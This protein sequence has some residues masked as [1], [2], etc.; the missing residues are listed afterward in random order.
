MKTEELTAL[1][2]GCRTY[3]RFKQDPVPLEV[4]EAAVDN[5]RCANCSMNKQPLRYAIATSSDL[6]KAIT[7][8]VAFAGR[9]PKEIGTP[10]SNEIPTAFVGISVMQGA[11]PFAAVDL[12]IAAYALTTTAWSAGVGSCMMGAF[13]KKAVGDLLQIPED[14]EL[15]LLIALGYPDHAS[16]VVD[17]S[18]DGDIG[19]Y[20]DEARDYYVPKLP[21][22]TVARFL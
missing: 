15:Q 22:E 5:A 6:V 3:R 7:E 1:F 21:R 8:N 14:Q 9:L 20:V 13:S 16:T 4:L 2:R 12:G 19:Y 10:K 18:A 11:S 17:V